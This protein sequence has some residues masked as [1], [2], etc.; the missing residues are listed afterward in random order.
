MDHP[1]YLKGNFPDKDLHEGFNSNA[2]QGRYD[3]HIYYF[4]LELILMLEKGDYR[5]KTYLK[6][7]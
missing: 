2:S 3:F 6:M 5:I 4:E 7:M 1:Y